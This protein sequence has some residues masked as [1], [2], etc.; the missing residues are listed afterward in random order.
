MKHPIS[1]ILAIL[2]VLGGAA[3]F[4]T[5]PAKYIGMGMAGV[6]I[7]IFLFPRLPRAGQ[8]ILGALVL[9]AAIGFAILEAPILRGAHTDADPEADYLIV[10][11]AKV[12]G[13]SPSHAMADRLNAAL[14]YLNAWPDAVVIVSGGQGDDEGISE[15]EAMAVWLKAHGIAEERIL[16]EDRSETTRQNLENSFAIIRD[17]GGDPADG[18]AIVTSEYHLYRARQ[19]AAALG[20][21]PIGVAARTSILAMR[22]NYFIREG[23]AVGYMKLAG[24]LY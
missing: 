14:D 15:A 8:L 3:V 19:I 5:S 24:T 23:I 9:L 16:K 17:R 12:N 2:L 10:L 20:A 1:M 11:G 21:K 13:T 7:L 4:V 22:V 6:G 18:V